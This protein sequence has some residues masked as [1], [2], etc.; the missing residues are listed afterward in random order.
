LS[1]VTI[2]GDGTVA[3]THVE[4]FASDLDRVY[5][6][7]VVGARDYVHKNGFT[8]VVIGLS[9]GIDSSIVAAIAVDASGNVYVVGSAKN[10]TGLEDIVTI[11]YNS[12][13]I[14]KKIVLIC[15]RVRGKLR[16]YYNLR[17]N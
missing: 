3:P 9:G 8:D 17:K 14:Q 4:P 15:R 11:K 13:G 1:V 12:S 7:L 16:K 10:V 6:A 2:G 5:D